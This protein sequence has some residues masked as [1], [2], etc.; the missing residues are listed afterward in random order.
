MCACLLIGVAQISLAAIILGGTSA[1]MYLYSQ[2]EGNSP[3]AS[4]KRAKLAFYFSFGCELMKSLCTLCIV[5][6]DIRQDA[7]STV[8]AVA[9][10]AVAQPA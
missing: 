2:Q 10:G 7:L 6:C 1:G 8:P 4:A 9:A 5:I 3:G